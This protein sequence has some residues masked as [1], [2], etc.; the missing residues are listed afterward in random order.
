MMLAPT[1]Q[2]DRPARQVANNA[3]ALVNE[4]VSGHRVDALKRAGYGQEA[5]DKIGQRGDIDL[6]VACDMRRGGC[7]DELALSI[8]L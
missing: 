5:A 6:H 2:K 1:K 3:S 4:Q 8:L 7:A